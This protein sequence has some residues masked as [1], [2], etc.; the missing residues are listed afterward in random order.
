MFGWVFAFFYLIVLLAVQNW[1]DRHVPRAWR[2]DPDRKWRTSRVWL[3]VKIWIIATIPAYFVGWL[4]GGSIWNTMC[5][6]FVAILFLWIV[7]EIFLRTVL[8]A[9]HPAQYQMLVRDGWDPFWDT[10]WLGLVNRDPPEV[11]A[12]K[13]PACLLGSG[14]VPPAGWTDRCRGCGAAQ[15]GPIFWCW[16]C[17]RGYEYGKQKI[18]CPD[19]NCNTTY[20][21]P[22]PG[23]ARQTPISCPG[24]G[25]GW[26]FP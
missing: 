23:R 24:C 18:C 6:T 1:W 7:G 13:P 17:S 21:E 5:G 25:R 16:F 11:T 4:I 19:D 26:Q 3:F 12:G 20:C 22:E 15:P 14:W 8:N 10:W 2:Y 9:F